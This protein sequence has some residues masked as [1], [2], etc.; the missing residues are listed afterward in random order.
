MK[1]TTTTLPD[2]LVRALERLD[3]HALVIIESIALGITKPQTPE[4]GRERKR[5]YTKHSILRVP[6]FTRKEN[7]VYYREIRK[8]ATVHEA[9]DKI[10]PMAERRHRR[11]LKAVKVPAGYPQ[12]N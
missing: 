2:S 7:A 1:T 12:V 5:L 8:G 3:Y 10:E 6:T 9:L 11:A 4:V